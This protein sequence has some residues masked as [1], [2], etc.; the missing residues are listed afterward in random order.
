MR[1]YSLRTLQAF[2]ATALAVSITITVGT[3]VERTATS[4]L[5]QR[6]GDRLAQTSLELA[7]ILDRAVYERYQDIALYAQTLTAFDLTERPASIRS[8]LDALLAAREGFAWIGYA[9][10]HGKV[11][12]ATGG[13]L[14]QQDVSQRPWFGAAS[15]APFIGDPRHA[16]MLEK[17]INGGSSEPQRLI[18]IAMPVNDREGHFA[19]VL[20]THLDWRWITQLSKLATSPSHYESVIVGRENSVLLGPG[21][22]QDQ[23]L[24]LESVHRAQRGESG[25]LIE[26]WPDGRLYLTGYSRA[27]GYQNLLGPQWVVLERQEVDV[28]FAPVA[29]LRRQVFLSGAA[30][31]GLFVLIG[32]F[33][34]DRISRPLNAITHTAVLLDK[35]ERGLRIPLGRGCR[36]VIVLSRALAGLIENLS[37]R[38]AQLEH[39]AT[40]HALT[41]LPNRALI[42]AMLNQMLWRAGADS[43]HIAVLTVDLDRFK[44]INDTLG[45]AAGDAVL[46]TIAA[47]LAGCVES[48][49]TL[50]HL[51]KDE[52]VIVLENQDL[53]LFQTET[54]AAQV[55]QEIAKPVDIENTRLVVTSSI[56]ISFY[57]RDGG[58]ADLLLGRST[59]AMRQ[60]KSK[61]GNRIE[62]FDTAANAV[63]LERAALERELHQAY[64]LQQFELVYQ[65]QVAL[66]SGAV[67][68][69]EALLRWRHPS[70]GLV[71]PALFLSAAETSGLISQIGTWVLM[72]ACMQARKWQDEGLPRLRIGVNVS[73][74]QF[75]S[76]LVSLVSEALA[77][78]GL[79]ADCIKLEITESTLMADVEAAIL[80]MEELR[81]LGVRIAID[82]FGT[83]Y[84][85]LSYLK[86]F[87]INDLKIDQSFIRDLQTDTEDRAIVR[88]II[89]LGH[90]LQLNVIAEGA[91][92][93]EQIAFLVQ[94]G[95]DEMQGYYVSRPLAADQLAHF[96]RAQQA[97]GVP[98]A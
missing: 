9:D 63:V 94:A 97:R 62:F 80:T 55:G 81:R 31:A 28:A 33:L 1:N 26:N 52:F 57:P 34:A 75:D 95:C 42:K 78:H 86:Q 70:R 85:S 90:S 17:Q 4:G 71:A 5:Q 20:G 67:V 2:F 23:T 10:R 66:A 11:Q 12:A 87:P 98:H 22:L 15:A 44:E 32:W 24:S 60:A 47:R 8:R 77:D 72:Q 38:E 25:Y 61:G 88:G 30:V 49:G 19:G 21:G 83:G 74:Q 43:R 50:G 76:R 40:H 27:R 64:A 82:D 16:V 73:A 93:G 51:A 29:T 35:G 96:L 54:L 56:G 14:E 13:I 89:A 48:R 65:P 36:E 59:F 45:Y 37:E 84:S 41:G 68:G 91:E 18:D 3:V 46:G 6:I 7:A 53:N 79:A 69:V 58:D 92:S 39:Q